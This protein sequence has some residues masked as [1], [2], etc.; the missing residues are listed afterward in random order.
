[1]N[2]LTRLLDFLKIDYR[3]ARAFRLLLGLGLFFDLIN[4]IRNAS[5]FY[6]EDGM[7]PKEVWQE[8]FGIK[9]YNWSFH[10]FE[11]EI[12]VVAVL[13]IHLILTLGLILGRY[14]RIASVVL[15]I[16][17]LSLNGRNPFLFY[18]GEKLMTALLLISIFIPDSKSKGTSK[19]IKTLAGIGGALILVQ[20]AILYAGSGISKLQGKGWTDG[21][22]M[23]DILQMNLL[24]YPLG[25]WF[26]QFETLN[27]LLTF[28]VPYV[29][30]ILPILLFLPFF[31]NRIR[32]AAVLLLLTL[33]IGIAAMLD[34]GY[35]MFY[36]SAALIACLPTSFW[37][38]IPF[39]SF[40]AK[41]ETPENLSTSFMKYSLLPT[42]LLAIVILGIMSFT[43]YE[44]YH[45]RKVSNY[46][47]AIWNTIR[48]ANLYQNWGLFSKPG[49]ERIWYVSKAHLENGKWVDI[50]Q[51]GEKVSWDAQKEPPALFKSNSKWRLA[52]GKSYKY[53]KNQK[54]QES[55]AKCMQRYWQDH[56]PEKTGIEAITLYRLHQ[57]YE[58]ED[59]DPKWEKFL[60]WPEASLVQK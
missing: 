56:Y 4:R 52:F 42:G 24:T 37:E 25:R 54:A 18:G 23:G 33:N 14:E 38:M 51:E 7:L 55:F 27:Y 40:K 47:M 15:W 6:T 35:F 11:N 58:L 26:G 41:M 19:Q 9:A 57:K 28:T 30:I 17:M 22:A 60:I 31:D 1:M 48:G 16:L 21:S 36:A 49:E 8:L 13:A 39:V 29:E 3:S 59:K 32:S 44:E 5:Y 10:F 20:T 43:F 53:R 46:P 12:L 50:M 2:T 45:L 34:V